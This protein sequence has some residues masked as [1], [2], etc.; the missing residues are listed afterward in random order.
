MISEILSAKLIEDPFAELEEN[1]KNGGQ[2]HVVYD[3]F[4]KLVEQA[5]INLTE[6]SG[7][8]ALLAPLVQP[9]L[10]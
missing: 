8:A 5:K 10:F 3:N 4:Q 6:T 2:I 7:A 9:P 1:L